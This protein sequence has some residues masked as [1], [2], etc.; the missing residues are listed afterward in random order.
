MAR[1]YFHLRQADELI[2]DE[3]G[4]ELPSPEKARAMAVDGARE[5]VAS[6]IRNGRDLLVDAIV[7]E[8][9]TGQ[10]T[11]LPVAEV[12]PKRFRG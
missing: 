10:T 1:Y 3:E 9:D 4:Q 2:T 8:D 5:L 11:L 12:L 7:I 6:A